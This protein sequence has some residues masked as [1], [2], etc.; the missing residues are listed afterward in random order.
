MT[1]VLDDIRLLLHS[2]RDAP[3]SLT[4]LEDHTDFIRSLQTHAASIMTALDAP[5]PRSD[6]SDL[7]SD[8]MSLTSI[9]MD[10]GPD[11]PFSTELDIA[12]LHAS[13]FLLR[14]PD[15]RYLP[16]PELNIKQEQHRLHRIFADANRAL[17]TIHGVMSVDTL[18]QVLDRNVSVLHFSGH[19]R[20]DALIFED[21]N[22]T[23]LGHVVDAATLR[24]LL[25]LPAPSLKL[26]F[27]SSCDS[28]QVG[29]VFLAAGVQHVVC[30]RQHERVLDDAS[31]LFA[32]AFYHALLHGKTVPAA[33]GVAQARVRADAGA[34]K[35]ESDKFVLLQACACGLGEHTACAC[36]CDPL[37]GDVP[38]G[39]F[40]NLQLHQP[41]HALPAPPAFVLGREMELH[42]L[43]S[44]IHASGRV[45]TLRGAPGIGKTTVALKMAHFVQERR[46]FDDGVLFVNVRGLA[47]A[48]G[49]DASVRAALT[50]TTQTQTQAPL[51]TL[52]GHVLLVLDQVDDAG[53]SSLQAFLLNL[54]GAAPHV[55]VLVTS[56]QAL[57]LVDEKVVQLD[58]LSPPVAAR[59]FLK[60]SPRACRR[61]D[62]PDDVPP[63]VEAALAQHPLLA[64]LDGHPQAISLCAALLHDKTLPELTQAVVCAHT[65]P[66]A[67]SLQV[68]INS[69]TD[70]DTRRFFA[71]QGFLP[72]GAL[73]SDLRVL[74]GRD[75]E[76]HAAVLCRYSLLHKRHHFPVKCKPRQKDA[77]HDA[78]LAALQ[79]YDAFV[80]GNQNT[81]SVTG[82][83]RSAAHET[84]QK[85]LSHAHLQSLSLLFTT[86]PFIT[87]YARRWVTTADAARW[88]AHFAQSLRWTYE[89]IGTFSAF[90]NAAYML[91]DIHEANAWM[92]IDRFADQDDEKRTDDTHDSD[93]LSE[94]TTS[95]DKT[96]AKK[97][98]KPTRKWAAA[99]TALANYLAHTLFLAGRHQGASR[100][101]K[102]GLDIAKAYGLKLAQANL[103]KL[104]ATLLVQENKLD[105]AKSQFTA[106]LLLYRASSGDHKAG[107]AAALTGLGLVHS[108]QGN[109]RGAHAD[110]GRA[111]ALFEWSNHVLGQLNCHQRLGHLEKKLKMGDELEVTQH[112][113]ACRRLQGDLNN[114]K[115][116]DERVRWVG[117]EMSLLLEVTE[118]KRTQAGDGEDSSS[119]AR[120]KTYDRTRRRPSRDKV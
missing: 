81:T 18:R 58:R 34:L 57:G 40:F 85:A 101:A 24:S 13:P 62:F 20:T 83:G 11:E 78:L 77:H 112:Y 91:L 28:R 16:L 50:L 117:H 96:K 37:F 87:T 41:K 115:D 67:T 66:L 98:N 6:K 70:P 113:A 44:L 79:H 29:Q 92:C 95:D 30:V 105:D 97:R 74:F 56:A 86:F 104:S 88:T 22:A 60:K 61:S 31:I 17:R 8:T 72:A 7:L 116:E 23:G 63:S 9:S 71:L 84:L 75:W 109:L 65:E 35:T 4:T 38:H 39:R 49:L 33:F 36:A 1:T 55:Q 106:A 27:V 48:E 73:A 5:P 118:E 64:F 3:S 90:S 110:F 89:Y 53:V 94:T 10:M 2:I 47:S 76:R 26:V 21:A 80:G 119:F 19:G 107:Q 46:V 32:D 45:V 111:L 93:D 103:T 51:A 12:I 25:C 42:A 14:L 120:R 99:T 43:A 100:A 102:I 114:N 82:R 54:L 52:L 59:L 15:S 108:R 69:L 68:A